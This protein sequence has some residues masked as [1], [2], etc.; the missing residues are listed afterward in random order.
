VAQKPAGEPFR[1]GILTVSDATSRGDREDKSGPMIAAWC[2][3]C[4]HTVVERAVV[5]DDQAAITTCLLGWAEQGTLDAIVTTGGTGFG[6]RD[7]TPEATRPVLDREAPGVAEEIRRRGV[8]ATPYAA[9][10]RGLAGS[11]GAVFIVNLP[12]SP[13][14]V[15]DGLAVLDTLLPH[16][17]ALLRGAQ[18]SHQIRGVGA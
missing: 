10:S 5:P 13:N 1:I 14:G 7:V 17:C 8:A 18:P 16:I 4:G 12:G 2:D 6:P 9:L 15:R 11:R 3:D